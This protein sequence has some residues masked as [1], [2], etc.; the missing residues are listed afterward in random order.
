MILLL[1][2]DAICH[3]QVRPSP[4]IPVPAAAA[5]MCCLVEQP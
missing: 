4:A 2:C 3:V 1:I 5:V